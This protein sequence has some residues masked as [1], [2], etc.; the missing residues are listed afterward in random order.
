[1]GG[2]G[3]GGAP[4]TGGRA[5]AT[6]TPQEICHNAQSVSGPYLLRNTSPVAPPS[7]KKKARKAGKK[8]RSKQIGR[9]K[10]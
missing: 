3:G 8:P 5:M 7:T 2:G 6:G 10:A 9:S 1:V 4:P